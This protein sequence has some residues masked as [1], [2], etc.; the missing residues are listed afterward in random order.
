MNIYMRNKMS[1]LKKCAFILALSLFSNTALAEENTD[2]LKNSLS[3]GDKASD[4]ELPNAYGETIKLSDLLKNGHVILTFYRGGWCPICN[5]QLHSYQEHLDTFKQYNTQLVAVSP[6]T[7]TNAQ[8]TTAKN[9]L[10]YEVLSDTGNK[11]AIDYGILWEVPKEKREKFTNWLV[12][13]TGKT[14]KDYNDS[15]E[16]Y[17]PIPATFIIK[18]DGTVIYAFKDVDVNCI[19]VSITSQCCNCFSKHS[20]QFA[21]HNTQIYY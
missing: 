5:V 7:P 13:K 17:L 18:Q 19:L 2:Y 3:V 1:I 21:K 6:E 8:L 4:F 16:F 14:L 12:T 9:H 20:L 11:L 10:K 15:E